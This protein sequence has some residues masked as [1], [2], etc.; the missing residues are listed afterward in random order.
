MNVVEIDQPLVRL[1]APGERDIGPESFCIA[2]PQTRHLAALSIEIP[3]QFPGHI[4][5]ACPSAVVA[6]IHDVVFNPHIV[7]A[8]FRNFVFG[9][10]ARVENIGYV[11]DMDDTFGGNPRLVT[12]IKLGWEDFITQK[13]VILIAKHR[14]GAGEPSGSVKFGVVET[15]LRGSPFAICAAALSVIPVPIGIGADGDVIEM[16]S[17][18]CL[19]L[20]KE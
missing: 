3:A 17:T 19:E 5:C 7:G 14:M 6:D 18:E 11:N 12:Q 13:N 10:L 1:S 15:K 8:R 2:C 20:T 16:R 9:N 4:D